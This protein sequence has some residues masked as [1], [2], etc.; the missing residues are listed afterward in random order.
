MTIHFFHDNFLIPYFHEGKL[1]FE[2]IS[3]NYAEANKKGILQFK[4][5]PK[6]ST[7][8]I[9]KKEYPIHKGKNK[10]DCEYGIYKATISCNGYVDLDT[11]FT[12]NDG[13]PLEEIIYQKNLPAGTL[14]INNIFIN[15][16]FVTL[17]NVNGFYKTYR[18]TTKI[19]VPKGIN[20]MTI[21]FDGYQIS[22]QFSIS[23]NEIFEFDFESEI[24]K[25]V[26]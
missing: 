6:K 4:K 3:E 14:Q 12:I 10:F 5:V 15:D 17:K 16:F 9:N 25:L 20:E 24:N 19:A 2:N 26:K 21:Y 18:N 23:Q 22:H 11:I 8:V 7:L 1:N 13:N